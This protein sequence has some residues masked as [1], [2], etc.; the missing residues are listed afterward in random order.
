MSR[1]FNSVRLSKTARTAFEAVQDE[2]R[3][4]GLPDPVIV[5]GGKHHAAL[6]TIDGQT[7]RITVGTSP[8]DGNIVHLKARDVKRAIRDVRGL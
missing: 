6:V 2:C 1:K 7:R 8:S 5:S 3:R 4:Q